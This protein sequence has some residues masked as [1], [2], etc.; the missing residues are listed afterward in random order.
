MIENS[1]HYKE[2]HN[3]QWSLTTTELD[4]A[5]LELEHALANY[6]QSNVYLHCFREWAKQKNELFLYSSRFSVARVIYVRDR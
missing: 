2:M 1:E 6:K 4:A 3:F 5:K